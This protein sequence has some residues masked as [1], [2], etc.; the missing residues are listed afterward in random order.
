M[1]SVQ[2]GSLSN[3]PKPAQYV[4]GEYGDARSSHYARECALR[5]GLSVRETVAADH[6]GYQAGDPSDRSREEIL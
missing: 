6:N 4:G 3:S 1:I 2:R 5:T